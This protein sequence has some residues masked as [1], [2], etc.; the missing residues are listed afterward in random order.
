MKSKCQRFITS[1]LVSLGSRFALSGSRSTIRWH[2]PDERADTFAGFATTR[3]AIL[4]NGALE[5]AVARE[6]FYG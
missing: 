4:T 1:A 6:Y 2:T 3:C 5:T